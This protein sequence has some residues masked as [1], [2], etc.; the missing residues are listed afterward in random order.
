MRDPMLYGKARGAYLLKRWL[1]DIAPF[2]EIDIIDSIEEWEAVKD[3]YGGFAFQR[4]DWPINAEKPSTYY[5][6]NGRPEDVPGLIERAKADSPEAVILLMVPKSRRYRYEYDGGFTVLF[7]LSKGEVV[8]E[9][10]GKAFDGHELTQGLAVHE[11]YAIPWSEIVQTESKKE[12]ALFIRKTVAPEEYAEQRKERVRYLID[13][14]HYDADIVEKSVPIKYEPPYNSLFDELLDKIV[15]KLHQEEENLV[16]NGL[17]YFCVQGN[18]VDREVQPW[19]IF[20][21]DRWA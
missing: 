10:V 1:P 4:V 5:G 15:F 3:K 21:P 14:C 7:D 12:L 18:F 16:R 8:I 11:S 17:T 9:V 6:T 13:D 19:E 2:T 20:V